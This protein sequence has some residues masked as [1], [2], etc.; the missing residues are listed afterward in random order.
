MEK[1]Q[2]T[3]RFKKFCIKCGKYFQPNGKYEKICDNCK[4]PKG[5]HMK[6]KITKKTHSNSKVWMGIKKFWYYQLG[7]D[8]HEHFIELWLNWLNII[9]NAVLKH[10]K[11]VVRLSFP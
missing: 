4:I 8:K 9:Y 7:I 11:V 10:F 2:K 6:N 5:E 3:M 1:Q